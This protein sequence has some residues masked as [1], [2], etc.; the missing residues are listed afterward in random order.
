MRT[1]RSS[2]MA[3]EWLFT[4]AAWR[5]QY[6]RKEKRMNYLDRALERGRGSARPIRELGRKNERFLLLFSA[7][8]RRGLRNPPAPFKND[9]LQ[10]I[11]EITELSVSNGGVL[12][13]TP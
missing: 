9:P 2:I 11:S 1:A 8:F 6:C 13:T 10:E 7:R 4:V 12:I 5:A 3:R